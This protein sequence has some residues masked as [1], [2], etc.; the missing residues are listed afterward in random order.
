MFQCGVYSAGLTNKE[1]SKNNLAQLQLVLILCTVELRPM[2]TLFI[3]TARHY[4]HSIV[5]K[6]IH[7]ISSLK[8]PLNRPSR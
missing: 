3:R 7:P 6:K 4:E 1:E 8:T 5:R 2:T